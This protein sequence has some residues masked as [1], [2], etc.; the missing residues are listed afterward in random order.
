MRIRTSIPVAFAVAATFTAVGLGAQA[1]TA[2]SSDTL[3]LVE[4]FTTTFTQDVAPTGPSIGDRLLYTTVLKKQGKKVGIGI[5]DCARL[6]GTTEATG[7]YKGAE[8]VRLPGGDVT[9]TGA[10]TFEHKLSKWAI[11]GGTGKYRGKT[12][13]VDFTTV[14]D[15]T[16]NDV[17][18][19]E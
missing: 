7:L 14:S 3:R 1:A 13:E 10:F 6:T 11:T 4:T 19:F 5:G 16:F 15:D 12:G 18:R 8:T 2:G 9:T 17:L